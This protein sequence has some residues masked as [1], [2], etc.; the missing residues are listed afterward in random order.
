MEVHKWL[1]H[2]NIANLHLTHI[3]DL[4]QHA[5]AFRSRVTTRESERSSA[6][7]S[8]ARA[9]RWEEEGGWCVL[10]ACRPRLAGAAVAHLAPRQLPERSAAPASRALPAGRR[11][12]QIRCRTSALA[13]AAAAV[14]A[15]LLTT[16]RRSLLCDSV[17]VT[18]RE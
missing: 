1:T 17:T 3:A 9:A 2:P 16:H 5:K 10:R 13:A 7:A 8:G 15:A 6:A 4:H 11:R 18:G 14:A 12:R